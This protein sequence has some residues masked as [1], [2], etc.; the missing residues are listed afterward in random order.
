M[1]KIKQIRFG[2]SVFTGEKETNYIKPN[3][4][5]IDV[6]FDGIKFLIMHKRAKRT[7]IVFPTNVQY[8]EID[9]TQPEVKPQQ[10]AHESIEAPR[11]AGRT[12][13]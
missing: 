9:S 8:A 5:Y 11:K 2:Q 1:T 10:E 6:Y 3:D 12:R 4:P 13:A 7:M